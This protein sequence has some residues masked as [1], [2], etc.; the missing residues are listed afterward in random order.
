MLLVIGA[1]PYG[2]ATAARAIEQGFETVV[3]GRPM[4][5]W[6]ENMPNGMFLRSGP[7]W[8][9]DAAEVH[10]FEEF[11]A[12][13]RIAAAD[14]DPVPIQVFLDYAD[15]FQR[16]KGVAVR[17]DLVARLSHQDG[18]FHAVF[19]S[20][21]A[22]T[23][24]AV[25]A[26]PGI[27][28]FQQQPDWSVSAP[29]AIVAHTCDLVR[30]EDLSDARVLIVGGRQSAYEWAALV[31]E[32]G[33][34]RIDIVHRHDVPRFDRVSWKFT[35]A[36]LER[37]VAVPGWWR[38]LSASEREAVARQF[39]E[40]GRLT[41]EWWLIPRL[42]GDR[43]HRWPGTSVTSVVADEA[44]PAH[45]SL[46]DGTSLTVDRILLATGYKAD[47]PRV[48]YL[49]GVIDQIAQDDGFPVLDDAFQSSLGGLYIPGFAATKDF[50]P[51][52]GFTKGCPAAAKLIVDDL[53][54]RS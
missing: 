54:R 42:T 8:H 44:G 26:A 39:W 50:G 46:S 10:T 24:D 3:V 33:A 17:E 41:L 45:V 27:R 37:T 29:A 51:F 23:A 19:D 48:P 21:E 28:Y 7:D 53:V 16:A 31:G 15:W 30:F 25:V 14:I 18:T 12:E 35:D 6:T 11:L 52:F 36:Y 1:G 13:R 47:L 5:F 38:R 34:E 2:V 20:G 4:G 32:Q 9:L 22:I 43:F 40:V 49:A